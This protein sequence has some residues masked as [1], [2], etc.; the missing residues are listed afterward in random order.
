MSVIM[1]TNLKSLLL[2]H[3]GKVRD[4]YAVDDNKLLVIQTA[5]L[6]A[7][8]VILDDPIS[9]KGKILTMMSNF[10]FKKL[11]H[12]MLNHVTDID[13][14]SVVS[15]EERALVKDWAVVVKKLKPLGIEAIVRGYMI[16]T[17]WLEYQKTGMICGISLPVGLKKAEK[18]PEVIFTLSTKAVV[19]NHDENITFEQMEKMIGTDIANQ[20]RN[21]TINLYSAVAKYVAKKGILIADAKFEFSIDEKGHVYLIDEIL[22]PDSSRFWSASS[23]TVGS[24]PLSFDKQFVRDWLDSQLWDKKVPAPKL[25]TD[26]AKKTAEKYRKALRLLTE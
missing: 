6:S 16:G 9:E 11:G 20:V 8:D 12:L 19:G 7:F 18:L 26:I 10:W 22:T 14:I 1:Q 13:P 24:S 3:R 5:R 25:P 15:F 17:G 23:Y 4:I 21:M 2:L